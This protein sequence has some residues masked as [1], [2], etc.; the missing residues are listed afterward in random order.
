MHRAL[1][2]EYE[3]GVQEVIEHSFVTSIAY[4]AFPEREV[5]NP[6]V[7]KIAAAGEFPYLTEGCEYF[8][9]VR[10]F[11]KDWLKN[12][13][14]EASDKFALNFYNA[15]KKSSEGQAYELP[16]Y[17]ADAM[18]DLLSVIIFTVT[19]YHEIIG[20][21]V[22]YTDLPT[23]AGFRVTKEMSKDKPQIDVQSFLLAS[24]ISGSTSVRMPKLMKEFPNFFSAAG[25]PD[26]EAGVWKSFQ[27]KLSAQSKVIQDRDAKRDFEFKYFDPYHFECSISV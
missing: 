12:A 14:D 16:T 19:G 2:L 5:K 23:K 22:D 7:K 27:D 9:I 10:D 24:I 15:M 13:G 3:G 17:S 1:P 21:V 26:W 4:Q 25:A 20:H 18:V 8:E 6:A 11:V